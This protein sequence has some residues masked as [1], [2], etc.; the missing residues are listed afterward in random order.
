MGATFR[1][2]VLTVVSAVVVAFLV[3]A[4]HGPFLRLLLAL[5]IA[6]V[7]ISL[8]LARPAAGVA[9]TF[10]YL[11]FV[12][13]VRRLLIPAA[14]WLTTDPLLLVAPLVAMTL[15]IKL[16][17]LE[18]RRLAPD[19]VS[20]LMLVLL[21][22]TFLEVANPTGTGIGS[23]LAGLLY[24][25]APL[26][27]FFIGRE[28]LDDA[29][30]DRLL[31]LLIV[32]S[33][34][35]AGFG[36]YQTQV[37]EPPWDVNWL[38]VTGGY[39]SLS[40][41]GTIRAF[42]VFS[43][44]A[45]YALFVGS[46]FALAVAFALR[47]RL[48]W[49]LAV[50]ILAVSLFLSSGRA[51]LITAFLGIVVMLGLRTRRP[52][53]ALLVAVCAVGIAFAGLKVFSSDLS[54]AGSGSALISHQIGGITDPLNPNSSTLIVHL[55][56]VERG[57]VTGVTHPFGTGPGST[58]NAAGVGQQNNNSGQTQ[59]TEVDISN[60]FVAL[61]LLGGLLYLGI[62]ILTLARGIAGYFGGREVMLPVVGFLVVGLGQWL[63][64][65]NY[66]LS[67]FTWLM[68]GALVAAWGR[69]PPSERRPSP[70]A[71]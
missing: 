13:F 48:M 28:V 71:R 57:F 19:L 50:P 5:L 61:G 22:L 27:W 4:G 24:M 69:P 63:T 40:V 20:K 52:G 30:I 14:G 23:N 31:M 62:V 26:F 1:F 49:L 36:L 11:V 43:S 16:F 18:R 65:G 17:V 9:A 12:A 53:T 2:Y 56:L 38:N 59:A 66:A 68:I 6:L 45:E 21:G 10:I 58:N 15:L 44:S 33:I 32:L 35:S 60:A 41:G 47:G 70:A 54:G 46:G 7:L 34:V 42:G 39:S 55:Q 37:A 8:S 29:W 3:V 51:A 25:A 64:G 67:P